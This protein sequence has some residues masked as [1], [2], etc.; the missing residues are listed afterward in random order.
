LTT[1][2]LG[3]LQISDEASG[4][5]TVLRSAASVEA[6][7]CRNIAARLQLGGTARVLQDDRAIELPPGSLTFLDLS[8][9]F[10]IIHQQPQRARTLMVPRSVIDLEESAL[11][12]LTAT[13]ISP[14][15][16][17]A[18]TV[19]L[20][21]LTDTRPEHLGGSFQIKEQVAR[22][23]ADLLAT[24]AADHTTRTLPD[25]RPATQSLFERITGS[26][27][28]SLGDPDLSPQGIADQHGVSLRYLHHLF[29]R[30]GTTVGAW[31]RT[32][33]LEGARQELTG[34]GATHRAVAAIGARWGFTSASHFS[35]A[36]R[37]AY[38][39]SPNQ[40]RTGHSVTP[41]T[42]RFPTSPGPAADWDS[43]NLRGP[44]TGATASNVGQERAN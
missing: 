27:E 10:K 44:L 18:A 42:A 5:V 32:R 1:T 6:D 30:Q 36:F 23:L 17:G 9:P 38:G 22:T 19:L 3:S 35:R 28:D 4:A 25:A 29:Q 21:L 2:R 33:R 16:G 11:R 40:C 43:D 15:D 34:P 39:M 20:P 31:I 8:R 41:P 37:D 7:P 13:L 14:A 12:R 24:L 26:V